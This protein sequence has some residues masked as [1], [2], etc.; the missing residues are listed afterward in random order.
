MRSSEHTHYFDKLWIFGTHK[1]HT[2]IKMVSCQENCISLRTICI[3]H[4]FIMNSY[5]SQLI[6]S[7]SKESLDLF[8]Y[9]W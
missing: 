2:H 6:H 3:I 7:S 5:C 9:T 4:E 1:A 8:D